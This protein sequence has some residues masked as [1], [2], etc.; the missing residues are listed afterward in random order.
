MPQ[1]W[2]R[3]SIWIHARHES[4]TNPWYFSYDDIHMSW[5]YLHPCMLSNPC[6]YLDES[7]SMRLQ[8][9]HILSNLYI[10][11]SLQHGGWRQGSM[12]LFNISFDKFYIS[13]FIWYQVSWLS[14]WIHKCS[15]LQKLTHVGRWTQIPSGAPNSWWA[16]STLSNPHKFN[17][18]IKI[19]TTTQGMLFHLREALPQVMGQRN[20]TRCE[21]IKMLKQKMVTPFWA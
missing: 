21:Y 8:L 18:M 11:K 5:I 6:R 19:N 2:S 4:M 13:N 12:K 10:T 3:N 7:K 20:S 16:T 14:F 1:T 15:S 9:T 17:Y